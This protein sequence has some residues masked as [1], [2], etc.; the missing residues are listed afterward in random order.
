MIN[1]L[2]PRYKKQGLLDLPKQWL[3]LGGITIVIVILLVVFSYTS[4][5]VDEKIAKQKLNIA[6]NKLSNLKGEL[7]IIKDLKNKKQQIETQLEDKKEILGTKLELTPIL[8]SLQEMVSD[9]SWI[10]SFNSQEDSQF[11]FVGYALNNQE[12]GGL[13]NKLKTSPKFKDVSI[14]LVK[15]QELNQ[16]QYQ[17][18]KVVYYRITGR[19]VNEGGANSAQLE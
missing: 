5:I 14:N 19:L 3:L 8:S 4:L 7:Q 10:I 17:E 13:F 9:N 1:L 15:Q 2:P 12:I 16:E 18:D 6:E 11:E